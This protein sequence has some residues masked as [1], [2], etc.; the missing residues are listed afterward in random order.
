ML[1]WVGLALMVDHKENEMGQMIFIFYFLV[2]TVC[3]GL[4]LLNVWG[5]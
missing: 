5:I 3:G 1:A 4:V 2:L